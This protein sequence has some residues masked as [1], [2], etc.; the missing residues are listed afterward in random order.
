MQPV[1][2]AER[3]LD[4]LDGGHLTVARRLLITRESERWIWR[5]P[6]P[7]RASVGHRHEPDCGRCA[8]IIPQ[9]SAA[10]VRR[11]VS[12][13]VGTGVTVARVIGRCRVVHA[14]VDRTSVVRTRVLRQAGAAGAATRIG[15]AQTIGRCGGDGV[16]AVSLVVRRSAIATGARA[17]AIAAC[18]GTASA[19]ASSR[20]CLCRIIG[21]FRLPPQP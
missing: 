20:A 21:A 2:S 11:S 18:A 17:G 19:D 1:G 9:P 15:I 7:T 4:P 5:W 10:S 13:V 12:G 16:T 8:C 14:S 6:R 3:R